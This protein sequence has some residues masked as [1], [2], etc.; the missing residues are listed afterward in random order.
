MHAVAALALALVPSGSGNDGTVVATIP[1]GYRLVDDSL[2]LARDGAK[3]A[4]VVS[5]A[6]KFR[7]VI[8]A[9]LGAE[10]D[11]VSP[12]VM[13]ANG[14]HVAFRAMTL[15]HNKREHWT[16]VYDGK[17]F[18]SDDWV[19]E[20]ALAPNDGTP[21]FWLS[22][23]WINN[24]DGSLSHGPMS[25]EFGKSK[26]K[27]WQGTEERVPPSFTRDG[28]LVVSVGTRGGDGIVIGLD[29][30]GREFRIGDDA[31]RAIEAVVSPDGSDVACSDINHTAGDPKYTHVYAF[32]LRRVGVEI[33]RDSVSPESAAYASAGSPVYSPDSKHVAY[34]I[35]EN[36]KFG[37]AI[38]ASK[39]APF[40]F[41]FVDAIV[42]KPDSSALAYVGVNGC[43]LND[44]NGF[45]V[46]AGTK[47]TGGKWIVVN[48]KQRSAE[49]DEIASLAWS[50]DGKRLA[51]AARADSQWR[52]VAGDKSS[53]PCEELDAPIWADDA[54]SLS[55]GCCVGSTISW[56]KLSLE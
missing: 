53:E 1:D 49:F 25:L 46:V 51:F 44:A 26:S 9:T 42:F 37:V 28:K 48:G 41:D 19:G 24:A 16:L 36:H 47:A 32:Y 18:A 23:G 34:K 21:A 56:R 6:K 17:P 4:F 5:K 43:K 30:K 31:S 14:A 27:K 22:H 15:D 8:G 13:Q 10:Y 7:P 11:K 2:R 12:P 35:E 55:Y 20:V 54:K 45:E 33:P 38:D 50:P 39:G 52:V 3:V 40:E 29:A